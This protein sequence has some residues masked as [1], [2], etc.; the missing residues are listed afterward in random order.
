[1][2]T[3]S[4]NVLLQAAFAK[5]TNDKGCHFEKVRILFDS[6][7]QVSYSSENVRKKAEVL[8][9]PL[10]CR[11]IANQQNL[12]VSKSYPN[13]RHLKLAVP[14]EEKHMSI[15]I[16]IGIDYYSSVFQGNKNELEAKNSYL[17]CFVSGSFFHIISVL[18][19]SSLMKHDCAVVCFNALEVDCSL[20][21]L[22]LV[23]SSFSFA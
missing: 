5:I 21:S 23:A 13:L 16:L 7:S 8:V 11:L 10:I 3:E 2:S 12:T 9:M 18:I 6:G 22:L 15:E 4:N 14:L 19:V 17:E 1:M 20:F